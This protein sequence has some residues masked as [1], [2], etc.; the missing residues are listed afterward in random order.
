[1]DISF[2]AGIF[3][4]RVYGFGQVIP[5]EFLPIAISREDPRRPDW[6]GKR[7]RASARVYSPWSVC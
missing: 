4:L 5:S 6:D 2:L 7:R 1:M 3:F